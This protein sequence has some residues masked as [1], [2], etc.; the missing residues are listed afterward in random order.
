MDKSQKL[1]KGKNVGCRIKL[2]LQYISVS[3][4][5]TKQYYMFYMGKYLS[6]ENIKT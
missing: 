1:V 2:S 3:L 4:K 5:Y 6:S